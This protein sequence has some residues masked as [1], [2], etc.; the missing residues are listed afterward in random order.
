MVVLRRLAQVEVLLR[1]SCRRAS[2]VDVLLFEHEWSFFIS[3][4]ASRGPLELSLLLHRPWGFHC[5]K[6]A[7]PFLS[8][9]LRLLG[10]LSVDY[11][12]LVSALVGKLTF[13]SDHSRHSNSTYN[14]K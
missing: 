13:S 7:H 4:S 9:E 10:P 1:L 6:I 3:A 14:F 8:A 11:Q 2:A 5:Y 12:N